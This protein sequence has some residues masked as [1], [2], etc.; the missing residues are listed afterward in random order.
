M[1]VK[2]DYS[3]EVKKI[4]KYPKYYFKLIIKEI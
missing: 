3:T 2:L 1:W 4:V